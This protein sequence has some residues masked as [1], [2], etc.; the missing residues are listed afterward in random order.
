MSQ[1][2]IHWAMKQEQIYWTMKNGQK[3][4]IDDM[5]NDHLR[6]TLKMIV[7]SRNIRKHNMQIYNSF[8]LES[9]KK[10]INDLE[11]ECDATET[12]IY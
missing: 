10:T 4:L 3:I 9:L 2:D 6:N 12:D 1:N 11:T 7:K 8:T 5:S